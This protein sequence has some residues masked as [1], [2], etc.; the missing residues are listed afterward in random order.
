M[1]ELDTLNNRSKEL[2]YLRREMRRIREDKDLRPTERYR[3]IEDI[4]ENIRY[5]K[6]EYDELARNIR[7]NYL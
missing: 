4:R 2:L 3:Q 7:K 1:L 5:C 6:Q